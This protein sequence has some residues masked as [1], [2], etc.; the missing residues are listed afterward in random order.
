MQK[1]KQRAKINNRTKAHR[2]R[3]LRTNLRNHT[4]NDEKSWQ[5]KILYL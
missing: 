2:N 4:K 5:K 3:G 1:D